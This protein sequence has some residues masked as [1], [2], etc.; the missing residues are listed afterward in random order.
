MSL[1]TAISNV[2]CSGEEDALLQ[3]PLSMSPSC[4]A[5]NNDAGVVCQATDTIYS[6]CSDG[7]IRLVNGSNI[8]EGRVELCINRAWGTVCDATFSEDEANVICNQTG[9]RY[10]GILQLSQHA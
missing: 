7:D 8:L 3:C 1:D 6:N 5:E 2:D 10:N 9:Y 4:P